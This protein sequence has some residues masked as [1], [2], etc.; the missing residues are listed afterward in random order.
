MPQRTL[1]IIVFT[2]GS[3]PTAIGSILL[4]FNRARRRHA[5]KLVAKLCVRDG[6]GGKG[7][8]MP[9]RVHQLRNGCENFGQIGS[10]SYGARSKDLNFIRLKIF[11][12]LKLRVQYLQIMIRLLLRLPRPRYT[13]H[14]YLNS[15]RVNLYRKSAR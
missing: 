11:E 10:E 3:R 4:P 12:L 1:S 5:G 9:P 14:A 7:A 6:I 8:T 13:S 2:A 15:I